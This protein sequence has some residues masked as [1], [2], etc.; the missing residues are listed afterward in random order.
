MQ[1]SRLLVKAHQ[2]PGPIG[3]SLSTGFQVYLSKCWD[4]YVSPG[5]TIRLVFF[6]VFLPCFCMLIMSLLLLGL[7][8]KSTSLSPGSWIWKLDLISEFFVFSWLNILGG[9]NQQMWLVPCRRQGM[10]TQGL[11]PDPK[12]KL[13]ISTFLKLPHLLDCLICTR[14]TMSIVL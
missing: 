13:I 1:A 11:T 14:N 6:W 3:F 5:C 4:P 12:C 10:P 2:G 8:S 9:W 7:G